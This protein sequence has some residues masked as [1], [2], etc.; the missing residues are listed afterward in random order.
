MMISMPQ[1]YNDH[2]PRSEMRKIYIYKNEREEKPFQTKIEEKN[3][4]AS[5]LIGC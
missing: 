5:N 4:M 2:T 3:Q 1:Y